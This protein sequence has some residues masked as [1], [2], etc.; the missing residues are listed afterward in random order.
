MKK[1]RNQTIN[2][3]VETCRYN[4]IKCNECML[5]SINVSCTCN[6]SNCTYKKETICDSFKEK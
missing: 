2:C 4:D 1:E 6:S 3:R 5:D